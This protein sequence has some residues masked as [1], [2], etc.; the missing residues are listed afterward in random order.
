MRIVLSIV[1]ATVALCSF[2]CGSSSNNT[3]TGIQRVSIIDKGAVVPKPI[4][5]TVTI[6]LTNIKYSQSQ[7]GQ[8]IGGWTNLIQSDDYS[9]VQ[10]IVG[11]N[12]L[13]ESGNITSEAPTMCVGGSGITITKKKNDN[14][15]TFDI[16]S[17]MLCDRAKWPA[18]VRDLV[19][20]KDTLVAQYSRI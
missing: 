18:G 3:D 16:N 6:D 7:A 20:L 19:N 11:D 10:K 17:D 9:N 15:H 14:D 2:G 5:T 1:L 12:N 8:I 13:F 4:T